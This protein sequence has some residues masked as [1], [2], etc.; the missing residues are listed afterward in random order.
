[1]SEDEEETTFEEVE[2]GI[3]IPEIDAEDRQDLEGKIER[4]QLVVDGEEVYHLE[5]RLE[6][7]EQGE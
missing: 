1:M 4:A 2:V 3:T 6:H 5:P 7:A